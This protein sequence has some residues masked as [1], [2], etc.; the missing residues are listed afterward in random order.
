VILTGVA[1]ALLCWLRLHT[2]SLAAPVLVH[3]AT[4][5]FALVGAF[6]VQRE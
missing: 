4:N 5:S 6:V 2:G 3:V 1:G